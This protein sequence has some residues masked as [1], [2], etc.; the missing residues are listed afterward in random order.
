MNRFSLAQIGLQVAIDLAVA[1]V[2]ALIHFLL[3]SS[4]Y[5]LH[6]W[7]LL[8]VAAQNALHITVDCHRTVT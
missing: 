8:M 4:F 3:L 1:Q 6:S 5:D 7:G 2:M